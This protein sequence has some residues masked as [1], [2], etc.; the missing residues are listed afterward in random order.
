M[1]TNHLRGGLRYF[2]LSALAIITTLASLNANAIP[3]FARQTG[4]KC[5]AC[6]VGGMYPQLTSLGRMFKLTGYTMGTRPNLTDMETQIDYPP[7]A[8]MVQAARQYYTNTAVNGGGAPSSAFDDQVYSLFAGGKITDNIGAFVQWTG[9]K[10]SNTQSNSKF[11]GADGQD[12]TEFRYADRMVDGNSDLIYGVYL[13]NRPSMSD[14]WNTSENW[15]SGWINYFN[16]TQAQAPTTF[17]D[18]QPMQHLALGV[19]T[20]AFLNKTWYGEIGVYKSVTHGPFS[21]LTSNA[22]PAGNG[23][24]AVID[25]TPYFRLAYNREWGAHSAEIGLHGVTAY[26][27]GLDP[28]GSGNSNWAGPVSIYRDFQLDGQY[29]YVLDPHYFA[30]H[31]RIGREFMNN[32]LTGPNFSSATAVNATDTLT[33]TYLDL[34]Y[35]Y[36]AK[37]GA[38]LSYQGANGSSDTGL[39]AANSASGSPDWS[40]WTPHIFWAPWQNVRVG[41]MYTIYTKMG[42]VGGSSR[43]L[44]NNTGPHDYNTGMI[45]VGV[46]Y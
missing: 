42:G 39:Y 22:S 40:A 7:V 1:K 46:V 23:T 11:T 36:K 12:N 37:Y 8:I 13:N 44:T 2:V 43:A 27:H 28:A 29:Q 4:F 34:T 5:V 31:A 33:E 26:A 18:S 9:Q 14:V 35:I 3:V 10:Y 21:L 19:G 15:V 32:N 16:P 6:H 38:L 30:A 20:Y 25:P 17:L 45:Y 24:A 41:A